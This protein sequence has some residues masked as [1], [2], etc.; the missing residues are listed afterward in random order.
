MESEDSMAG[1]VMNHDD[2]DEWVPPTG[3][4]LANRLFGIVM[5]GVGAVIVLM[6]LVAGWGS[7][8]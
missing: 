1:T 8:A 5:A 3:E 7:A 6:A 2:H 4:E